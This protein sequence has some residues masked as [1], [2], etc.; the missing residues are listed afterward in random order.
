MV[1]PSV[2]AA[3]GSAAGSR[4]IQEG[5]LVVVYESFNAIKAVYVDKKGQYANRYGTFLHKVLP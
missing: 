1:I 4:T 3:A 5:D 2:A